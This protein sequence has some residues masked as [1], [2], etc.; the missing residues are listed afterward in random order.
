MSPVLGDVKESAGQ[1]CLPSE[2]TDNEIKEKVQPKSETD[3]YETVGETTDATKL[4]KKVR[5]HP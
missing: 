3:L 4:T 2:M 1:E 5:E